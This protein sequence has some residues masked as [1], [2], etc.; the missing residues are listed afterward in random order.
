M[1]LTSFTFDKVQPSNVAPFNKEFKGVILI[2]CRMN[3]LAG[4]GFLPTSTMEI[5]SVA[6]WTQCRQRRW[7]TAMTW[8]GYLRTAWG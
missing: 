3:T 5:F 2:G 6:S 7:N 8:G 1:I 4:F